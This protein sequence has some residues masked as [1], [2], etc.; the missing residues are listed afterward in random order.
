DAAVRGTVPHPLLPERT[1]RVPDHVPLAERWAAALTGPDATVA[2][3]PGDDPGPLAAELDA[4]AAAARRPSGPL[5]ACFRLAGPPE[6]APGGPWSVDFA[7]QG[8][9]APSLY[10]TAAAIW[11]GEAPS[12]TDAAETLLTGLGRALRLYPELA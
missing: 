10:V 7:V 2:R 8:T 3:E 4:W 9:H 11:A 6:D 12:V 1:G 5:K